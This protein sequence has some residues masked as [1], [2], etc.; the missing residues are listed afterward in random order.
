M[1]FFAGRF[2]RPGLVE[3][4]LRRVV[5]GVSVSTLLALLLLLPVLAFW[6]VVAWRCAMLKRLVVSVLFVAA[7]LFGF[8]SSVWAP[9]GIVV[10][11]DDTVSVVGVGRIGDVQA[12]VFS[13]G[14]SGAFATE[15]FDEDSVTGDD[16][17]GFVSSWAKRGFVPVSGAH[18]EVVR[19]L[20][21]GRFEV[22][23]AGIVVIERD[24]VDSQDGF[25]GRFVA[26]A[27]DASGVVVAREVE[28]VDRAERV[29]GDIAM[30]VKHF[31]SRGFSV[32]RR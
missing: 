25:S 1:R 32:V 30:F 19:Q 21:S 28:E 24:G 12:I 31:E 4:G 2:S 6:L 17:V 13:S 18:F 20:P 22:R 29:S 5:S 16:V 8:A 3:F 10:V 23:P 14:V 26:V 9:A 7:V 11:R 15:S 27:Y